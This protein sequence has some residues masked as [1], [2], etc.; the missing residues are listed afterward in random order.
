MQ[1]L[2]L[3]Y[4]NGL[5][6]KMR[7]G[8]ILP[9]KDPPPPP[10]QIIKNSLKLESELHEQNLLCRRFSEVMSPR[11]K[12]KSWKAGRRKEETIGLTILMEKKERKVWTKGRSRHKGG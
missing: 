9:Q 10:L 5:E 7:R 12:S 4:V 3:F 11:H 8:F 6:T 1:T 2:A